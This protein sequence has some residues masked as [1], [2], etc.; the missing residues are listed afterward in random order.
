L[1]TGGHQ[2][3]VSGPACPLM[4]LLSGRRGGSSLDGYARMGKWDNVAGYWPILTDIYFYCR[5][6][7]GVSPRNIQTIGLVVN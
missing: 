3:G 7:H 1:Q 2:V 5:N 4:L 6:S